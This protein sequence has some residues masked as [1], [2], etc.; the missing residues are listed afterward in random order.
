M[1]RG[2]QVAEAKLVFHGDRQI[3]R[4]RLGK[5][6]VAQAGPLRI[7][8]PVELRQ[9]ADGPGDVARLVVGLLGLAQRAAQGEVARGD[10]ALRLFLLEGD[11][12]VFERLVVA[13]QPHQGQPEPAQQRHRGRRFLQDCAVKVG[14]RLEVAEPVLGLGKGEL[15]LADDHR[16]VAAK[17]R[18]WVGCL[19][20]SRRTKERPSGISSTQACRKAESEKGV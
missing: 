20:A 11:P 4:S 14:R 7:A 12:Q 1:D 13:L 8:R 6:A 19:R 3:E 16:Q 15:H 9:Q 5:H 18:T 2:E 10:V 17:Q